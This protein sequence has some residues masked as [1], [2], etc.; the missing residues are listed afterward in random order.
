MYQKMSSYGQLSR[1]CSSLVPA[2]GGEPRNAQVEETLGGASARE[3]S[4]C[5]P[6]R[7]VEYARLPPVAEFQ[8][9]RWSPVAAHHL[10]VRTA[11]M[12]RHPLGAPAAERHKNPAR[13]GRS[14]GD[15]AVSSWSADV[16]AVRRGPAGAGQH[17]PRPAAGARRVR[18]MAA[19]GA[20]AGDTTEEDRW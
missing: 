10:A 13:R 18:Y 1:P 17:E 7:P 4:C 19:G 14:A 12:L 5:A 20:G 15:T 6:A 8:N 16:R 9:A 11:A 2:F 3:L